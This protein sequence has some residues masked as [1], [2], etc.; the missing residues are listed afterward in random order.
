MINFCDVRHVHYAA[1]PRNFYG[2]KFNDGF[3]EHDMLLNKVQTI[4]TTEFLQQLDED[5]PKV[6]ADIQ[7]DKL[8][9]LLESS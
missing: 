6:T 4:F 7:S 8:K 5:V 2:Y 9:Q 1:C 3:V